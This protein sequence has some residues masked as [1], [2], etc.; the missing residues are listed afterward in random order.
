MA[1]VKVAPWDTSETLT[2]PEIINSYL[3]E[4][5]ED[6]DPE[7]I[8]IAM[9]NVVKAR[10]MTQ[11]AAEMGVSR[12]GLYKML[13]PGGNPE[14]ETIQKFLSAIGSKLTVVSIDKKHKTKI[15]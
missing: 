5:F 1:K 9:T 10:N 4:A 14:F 15:G 6:G 2:S 8:R 13:S 12:S 3:A 7:L 11:L